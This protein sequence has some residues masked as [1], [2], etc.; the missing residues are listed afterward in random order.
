MIP[1]NVILDKTLTGIGATYGELFAKRNSIIIEPNVPVILC[2]TE[3]ENDYLGVYAKTTDSQIKAYLNNPD[4]PYKKIITT[5]E[6]FKKVRKVATAL[7]INL[8]TDF[9]CLFDECEKITQDSDY[10][11]EISQPIHDFFRFT[12]KAFVSATPLNPSHPDFSN[13]NFYKIKIQPDY[14]YKK[15]ITLIFTNSFIIQVKETLANLTDSE[16][17]CIFF[18]KTDAINKLIDEL[19]ITDYK[20]FC[21]EKSVKKLSERFI[22]KAADTV[23]LPLAKYNFFTCRF[24]SGLDIILR[25][26]NPD[27]IIL[28]NL[29]TATYT[30][31]DPF[32]DAVQIQGRFRLGFNSLTHITT[33][34]SQIKALSDQ[35]IEVKIAVFKENYITAKNNHTSE[36]DTFR[37]QAFLEDMNKLKYNDFLDDDGE[38]NHF[39]ID[40]YHNEERVKGYYKSIQNLINAYEGTQH[41]NINIVNAITTIGQD[42]YMTISYTKGEKDRMKLIAECLERI[43][44][45]YEN[46]LLDDKRR[47][48]YLRPLRGYSEYKY[49][50]S[51]FAK[52]GIEGIE[53]AKYLK[54]QM[55]KA[56]KQH[57]KEQA[58]KLRFSPDVLMAI[59]AEF[60]IEV[61]MT[62]E[63]IKQRLKKI[64]NEFQ[65]DHKVTQDTIKD[66]FDT[67]V[68]GVNYKLVRFISQS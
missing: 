54:G 36:T 65:I 50:A 24:Y 9:F 40:N 32:T 14:D 20:I 44:I 64:Y 67:K 57:D 27:I 4:I 35:E 58:E 52:I 29:A 22:D 34:N 8:Y 62:K 18:N 60:E 61:Y 2:K 43:R 49:I 1:S 37:K 12:N 10:R 19:N 41:F 15:D 33:I 42:D 39:A 63:E 47:E 26:K 66:Y 21:S 53:K 51:I 16:C 59:E 5:P 28:T 68:H 11:P 30:A 46:G 3:N 25:D 56:V 38:I 6:S 31:I 17:I 23:E 55:N 13:Q 7:N 45:D 48:E